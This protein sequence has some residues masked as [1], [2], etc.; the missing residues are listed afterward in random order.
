MLGALSLLEL[1][2]KLSSI[3]GLFVSFW[4]SL[5]ICVALNFLRYIAFDLTSV[6]VN[7]IYKKKKL[8]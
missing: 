7:I 6:V 1:T 4:I 3:A 5:Y 2:R 8:S